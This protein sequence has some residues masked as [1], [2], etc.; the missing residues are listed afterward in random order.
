MQELKNGLESLFPGQKFLQAKTLS[1]GISAQTT[2]CQLQ[3]ADG[4]S[5]WLVVRQLGQRVLQRKP[6]AALHEYE[7]LKSLQ[8]L[9]LAAPKPLGCDPEGKHFGS[10]TLVMS[11]FEGQAYYKPELADSALK[12]MAQ[13]LARL[14]QLR[15]PPKITLPQQSEHLSKTLSQIPEQPDQSL[16]EIRIRNCLNQAWPWPQNPPSLLHGDFWPGNLLWQHGKLIAILDWEEAAWGDPLCDLAIAR[17]DICW[18]WGQKA[19]EAFTAHY[20]DSNPLD[21]SCLP[22]WDLAAAL[23]P[24]GQ[25]PQWAQ[26]WAELGRP[27]LSLARM[28]SIHQDFCQQAF[29]SLG[30]AS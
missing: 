5:Y 6:Q 20:L 18:I 14:H 23:R 29:K 1:G 19:M 2:A 22:L 27:D 24:V 10:P 17:L 26:G 13:Q 15:Q 8:S 11:Y 16:N 30:R 3:Q 7:I 28:Q 21:P 9:G 4:L 25:L 12:Q